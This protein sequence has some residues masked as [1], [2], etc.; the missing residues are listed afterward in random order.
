MPRN[1][2]IAFAVT[3]V[4]YVIAFQGLEYFRTRKGPWEVAFTRNDEGR[5]VLAIDQPRLGLSEVTLVFDAETTATNFQPQTI[6]FDRPI[7]EL[8]WGRVL[9]QDPTEQPGVVTLLLF[10]HEIE[11]MPRTLVLNRK[12]IPWRSHSTNY[13]RPADKLPQDV[14]DQRN[15]KREKPPPVPASAPAPAP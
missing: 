6:R 4:I 13:L 9:F 7:R 12:E 15:Y 11:L 3:V 10:G 14:L 8:P 1:M 5:P 2:L